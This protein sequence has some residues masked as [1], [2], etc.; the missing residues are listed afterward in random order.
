MN[1]K[2]K[3]SAYAVLLILAAW[4]AWGFHKY[5]TIT[6]RESAAAATNDNPSVVTNIPADSSTNTAETSNGVAAPINQVAGTSAPPART[7]VAAG[8]TTP[9]PAPAHAA[10]GTM[11]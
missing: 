2:F 8:A 1:I 10:Q 3:L 4:F 11:I 7:N 9:A 6:A 5:Y